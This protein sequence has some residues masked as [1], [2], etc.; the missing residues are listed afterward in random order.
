MSK[1]SLRRDHV[2][3]GSAEFSSKV[4]KGLLNLLVLTV[5]MLTVATRAL[6]MV[7]AML[8]QLDTVC[9]WQVAH[10]TGQHQREGANEGP[11]SAAVGTGVGAGV[12]SA[13]ALIIFIS[14][15]VEDTLH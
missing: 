10:Q 8:S 14:I 6:N 5:H 2:S 13:G 1:V 15:V 11:G 12:V 4:S 9:G 3:K 7:V